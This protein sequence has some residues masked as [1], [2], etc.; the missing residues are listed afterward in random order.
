MTREVAR[1]A[2]AGELDQLESLFCSAEQEIG[3]NLGP[4]GPERD[5]KLRRL[6][7][8]KLEAKCLWT[9]DGAHALLVLS[10]DLLGRPEEVQYVVV[11][12]GLRSRHIGRSLVA[13]VQAEAASLVAEARNSASER[14]LRACGFENDGE[15]KGYPVLRWEAVGHA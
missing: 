10:R 1:L 6:F 2:V 14:M 15:R 4:P 12:E 7:L 3:M 13:A 9:T 11:S 8:Q 5:E